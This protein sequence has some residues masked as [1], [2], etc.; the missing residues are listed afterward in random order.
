MVYFLDESVYSCRTHC[1]LCSVSRIS[2]MMWNWS[3]AVL[4]VEGAALVAFDGSP[5]HPDLAALWRVSAEEGVTHLGASPKYELLCVLFACALVFCSPSVDRLVRWVLSACESKRWHTS[6]SVPHFEACCRPHA[7]SLPGS[8][9][10][11]V[12]R[13][14]QAEGRCSWGGLR[15]RRGSWP[16]EPAHDTVDRFS[17]VAGA[18]SVD[19]RGD[20]INTSRKVPAR[21]FRGGGGGS[22]R[23]MIGAGVSGARLFW[24]ATGLF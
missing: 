14:V 9:A 12:L 2:Q 24:R 15:R 10:A 20:Q 7:S 18:L 19:L 4:S 5:G 23:Y 6:L 22:G 13:R 3:A 1:C 16:R 17:V 11:Q 21:K 8:A